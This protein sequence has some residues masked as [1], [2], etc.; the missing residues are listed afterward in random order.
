[1]IQKRWYL[2]AMILGSNCSSSSSFSLAVGFFWL[3]CPPV[4]QLKTKSGNRLSAALPKAWST[5]APPE[6]LSKNE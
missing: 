2:P 3:L 5:A 4:T 1:M 6:I